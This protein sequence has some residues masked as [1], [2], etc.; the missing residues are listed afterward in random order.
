VTEW[1][2]RFGYDEKPSLEESLFSFVYTQ[3]E[4]CRSR[5][6]WEACDLSQLSEEELLG[7]V[8]QT[9]ADKVLSEM[10]GVI[11]SLF[12]GYERE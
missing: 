2:C 4:L 1:E 3:C 12:E 8:D 5:G 6:G 7:K 10:E 11:K 9:K